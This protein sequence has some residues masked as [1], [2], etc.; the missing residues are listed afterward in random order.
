MT[1]RHPL[2]IELYRQIMGDAECASRGLACTMR[3]R[4][5]VLLTLHGKPIGVWGVPI[6]RLCFRTVDT[7]ETRLIVT[8]IEE[9]VSACRDLA[10]A[11]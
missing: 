8:E 6:D 4:Y 9:A 1:A 5:G 2:E 11:A 10:L 3:T 7:W